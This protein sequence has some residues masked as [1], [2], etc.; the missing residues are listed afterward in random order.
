MRRRSLL[1][2][3][4]SAGAFGTC[5]CQNRGHGAETAPAFGTEIAFELV[6]TDGHTV[7]AA[8]FRGRWLL[9][10]FGYTFCPD[11]CPTTLNEIAHIATELGPLAARVQPIFISIDPERDTP[12]ALR[13]YA[14]GFDERILALTGTPEQLDRAARA[15]GIVFFKLPGLDGKDY[16][17][18]H[19]GFLSLVGPEGGLVARFSTDERSVAIASALKA[20]VKSGG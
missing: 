5:L 9:V 10:F 17:F 19:S 8:D 2:L 1:L 13:E 12:Q 18:A 3:W 16:T 11:L 20:L 14:T 4:L 6:D 7:R 15:F